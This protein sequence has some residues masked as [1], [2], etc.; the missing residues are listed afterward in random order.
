MANSEIKILYT[1]KGIGVEAHLH[2]DLK[3]SYLIEGLIAHLSTVAQV[4]NAKESAVLFLLTTLHM[5]LQKNPD[6]MHIESVEIK[7]PRGM[8]FDGK[9]EEQ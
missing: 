4:L 5:E 9:E 7:I 6:A 2:G 8:K 1:D 3:P